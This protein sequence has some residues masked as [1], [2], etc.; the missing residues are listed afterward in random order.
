[1]KE[2]IIKS[3]YQ[4]KSLDSDDEITKEQVSSLLFAYKMIETRHKQIRSS[5]A[6]EK[7][8]RGAQRVQEKYRKV[9]TQ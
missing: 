9:Y 2:N 8:E 3:Q 7:F 6:A 5:D 4:A 1:M